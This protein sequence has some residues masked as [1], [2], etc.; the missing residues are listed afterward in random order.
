MDA[1]KF[2]FEAGRMC[3]FYEDCD[4]CRS[5]DFC[6]IRTW[7][8]REKCKRFVE[9]IEKF[10]S[11]HP[12]KTMLQDFLEKFPHTI[13]DEDNKIPIFCPFHFGYEKADSKICA[14]YTC[15]ECWNRP[16]EG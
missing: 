11:E 3:N 1:V 7:I 15:V 2:L 4:E 13:L 10:S 6:H 14:K 8:D 16:V 9:N 5:V 12:H